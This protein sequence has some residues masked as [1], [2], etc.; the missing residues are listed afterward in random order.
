MQTQENA[1]SR[2]GKKDKSLR[3]IIKGVDDDDNN[4]DMLR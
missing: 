3:V 4:D 1:Y 2:L